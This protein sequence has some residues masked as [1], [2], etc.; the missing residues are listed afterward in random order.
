MVVGYLTLEHSLKSFVSGICPLTVTPK[1]LREKLKY[2]N[3]IS[4]WHWNLKVML[5]DY[6]LLDMDYGDLENIPLLPLNNGEWTTISRFSQPIYIC[7][8]EEAGAFLGMDSEIVCVDLPGSLTQTL[9]SVAT[10][11]ELNYDFSSRLF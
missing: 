5:L 6:I 11:G 10:A 1:F 8:R 7:T 2:S 3:H 9:K 4:G